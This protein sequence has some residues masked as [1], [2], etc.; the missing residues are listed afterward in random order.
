VPIERAQL[1]FAM[2]GVTRLDIVLSADADPEAVTEMLPTTVG[3]PYVLSTPADLA[4]SLQASTR[5]FRATMALV[6]AIA[7]FAGAFL[8]FNTLSMTVTERVRDVALLRAA[9]ATA[10]QVS[11]VVLLEALVM[12]LA[13]VALGLL[14]GLGLAIVLGDIVRGAFGFRT[15]LDPSI[16]GLLLV[17]AIGLAVTLAAAIE[18]ARRAGSIPPVAALRA[19]AEPGIEGRARLRWLAV[20][21]AVVAAAGI[22][23]WPGGTA[24]L[25][26]TRPLAVYGLLLA[27]ALVSPFLLPFLGRIAG[28]PFSVVLGVEERLARGALTRDRSRTA[29]TVGALT[30]G[31]ALVVAIGTVALDAR[32]SAS[33]WIEDV[34]PGDEL[35]T[36][37]TPVALGPDGPIG[38]FEAI[39]G[40]AL[41]SPMASFPVAFRGVRLDASA[42]SGADLE[43]D[44]RLTFVEGDRATALAALDST[45]AVLVPEAHATRLDLAVGDTMELATGAEAT[46]ALTVAGI[47]ER[48]MPGRGGES[49]LVGWPDATARLGVRGA[50]ALAIRYEAI[51]DREVVSAQVGELARS[52]ALQPVPIERV[53]GAVNEALG[54]VFGLFDLLAL[55]A[56]VVAALGILNTLAMD[57]AERV[58]EI[59]ILR[60]T[61]MTRRQVGRMVVVEAGVLG[62]TGAILGVVTGLVA[63]IVL[64]SFA[65]AR[66]LGGLAVPWPTIGLAFA[67]GVGLAMLAAYYPARLASRLSI[68]RAVRAE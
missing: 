44:G 25:E 3:E 20:V 52:L 31:L 41:V 47:V 61:G 17:T 60:A 30:I 53:E 7:L 28:L 51:A 35:L 26:V 1:L 18:P 22:I 9:G 11:L 56:V 4:D 45:G 48:G 62:L 34:I 21:A 8:I 33:L 57:V 40:V 63:A 42:V 23:L 14:L 38:A 24:G 46:V 59:G 64:L 12:G 55:I 6:A 67:L 19:R 29:L 15:S 43:A 27:V 10:G 32:R 37:V 39:E 2:D 65:D 50:D 66:D 54:R 49:I 68:V 58:R 16:G 13:G 36:A 5:E